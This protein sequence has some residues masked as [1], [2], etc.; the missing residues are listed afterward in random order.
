MT[1]KTPAIIFVF[2]I[3]LVTTSC[4]P[5]VTKE[6]TEESA[7][8]TDVPAV[9][10]SLPIEPPTEALVVE[11]VETEDPITCVTLLTPLNGADIPAVGKATFT[12]TPLDE[13]NAYALNIILPTGETVTFE[14]NEATHDRYMEAFT[15]GGTY[16]WNVTALGVDGSQICVSEV[17]AFEKPVIPQKQSESNDKNNDEQEENSGSGNNGNNGPGDDLGGGDQ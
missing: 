5:E 16:Q 2:G 6:P 13:A 4:A 17:F 3:I 1:T 14:T 15:Q 11:P 8:T 7:I 9:E 12:W 10:E